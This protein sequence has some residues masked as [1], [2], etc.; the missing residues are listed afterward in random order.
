MARLIETPSKRHPTLKTSRRLLDDLSPG[1]RFATSNAASGK[2]SV[3]KGFI[4]CLILAAGALIAAAS[5]NGANEITGNGRGDRT[6]P[7]TATPT[8]AFTPHPRPTPDPCRQFPGD[9]DLR[10]QPQR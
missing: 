9:C 7:L 4:G 8:P 3:M 1:G 5:C 10:S 2:E 6:A